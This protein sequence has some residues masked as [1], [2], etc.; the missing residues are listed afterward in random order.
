MSSE[1]GGRPQRFSQAAPIEFKLGKGGQ[2]SES[3][4]SAWRW[5]RRVRR[6]QGRRTKDQAGPS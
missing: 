6:G 4:P 1:E 3:W 5:R 2:S